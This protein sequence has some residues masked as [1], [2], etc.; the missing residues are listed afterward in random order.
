VTTELDLAQ[1]TDA[2]PEEFAALI[3][4]APKAH[5]EGL[6]A[7]EHRDAIIDNIFT[8]M[9]ERFQPDKAGD[10]N[11]VIH[12]NITGR[13]DGGTDNY[14]LVIAN[15]TCT[16]TNEPQE[17]PNLAFTMGGYEF[18]RLIVGVGSPVMMFMTGKVKAKGDLSLAGK[19]GGLFGNEAATQGE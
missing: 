1:F 3:K 14:E 4:S 8:A 11:A 7:T 12:W 19:I 2:S 17:E 16:A 6:L 18:L 10:L 15:G 5:V 13:A 9:A